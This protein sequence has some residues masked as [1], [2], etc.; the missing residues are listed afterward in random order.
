[1][2]FIDVGLE[3]VDVDGDACIEEV[4]CKDNCCN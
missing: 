2:T 4:V 3:G 1:M